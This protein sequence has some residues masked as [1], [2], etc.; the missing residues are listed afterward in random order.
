MRFNEHRKDFTTSTGHILNAAHEMRPIEETM[1]ITHFENDP[2]RINNLE[3]IE[4]RKVIISDYMLNIMQNNKLLYKILQLLQDQR[5]S[6]TN[7][8]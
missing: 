2:K 3:E 5:A 1:T 8:F 4:I 6:S 7:K